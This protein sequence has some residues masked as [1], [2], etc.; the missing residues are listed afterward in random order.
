MLAA[1]V[2]VAAERGMAD[3][4]VAH[5]VARSGVSRRT[6]YEIFNGREDC[7]LA[8]FE[9]AVERVGEA[10]SPA[11]LAAEEW[12]DRIRA[13]LTALLD[14][15]EHNP[16]MAHLL[17]V[18]SLNAGPVAL[19]HRTAMLE[20][21]QG[22]VEE[23][24]QESR[25]G[26]S[27]PTS[28][29]AEGVVGAVVGVIQA[30]L[31]EWRSG[32]FSTLV[33]PLMSMIVLPYLGRAASNRELKQV[34]RDIPKPASP[35][36]ENDLLREIGIRLTYRTVRVLRAVSM[37]PRGSNRQIGDSAGIADQG[38]ISKLLTRLEGLGLVENLGGD[39]MR[40]APN[41]WVL[42]DKGLQLQ[43]VVNPQADTA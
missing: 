29:T 14:F 32:Q 35:R 26:A 31:L 39:L 5:V 15:C 20:R 27:M 36:A 22:L 30:R 16:K 2:D 23:G 24:R 38:Q 40:G 18:S 42:T 8:A 28:L 9:D 10:V 25:K 34:V 4:A 41:E 37:H 7:F 43:S 13:G 19:A 17:F 6:F 12:R 33:N 1:M 11:Y 21:L 3:T